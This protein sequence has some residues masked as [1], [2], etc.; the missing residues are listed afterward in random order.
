MNTFVIVTDSNADLPE[1]FANENEIIELQLSFSFDGVSYM[2]NDPNMPPER[3][4]AIMREGKMPQSSAVNMQNAIEAMEQPAREG[5][6][7]LC[8]MFS[9]ALSA[10]YANTCMAASELMSRYPGCKIEVIDSLCASSGQGLLVSY[11]VEYR[12]RGLS[13]EECA[14]RVSDDVLHIAHLFT[15]NDLFHLHRGGRVSAASAVVGSVLG[16]KPVL[17]VDDSG[18]LS[19]T[20]K[21]RGRRQSL[22]ALVDGMK[23]QI[24]KE[25]CDCF[26][27]SHGDCI[28]DAK[29][30]AQQ[31]IKQFCIVKHS[32]SFVGPAIGA[33][34]G[35]GTVALF[36]YASKR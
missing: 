14:R 24:D 28:E 8:I 35:P 17:H 25:R 15:V 33:H 29:F 12:E 11:A 34:S 26:A 36:F 19:P 21:V 9:S 2:C 31:V 32:I 5:K 16:I 10:T 23:E 30:V 4:Y 6:K 3:F 1:N 22:L 18:K 7:I 13:M 20:G 27:I